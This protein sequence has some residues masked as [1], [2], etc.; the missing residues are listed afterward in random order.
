MGGTF[1]HQHPERKVPHGLSAPAAHGA[2]HHIGGRQNGSLQSA[3]FGIGAHTLDNLTRPLCFVG[4]PVSDFGHA[5]RIGRTS[6]NLAGE[7]L[8]VKR[9][10][11]KGLAQFVSKNA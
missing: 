4:N 1:R 5:V 9:C 6:A 2:L 7:P 11:C 10:R 8:R 3:A